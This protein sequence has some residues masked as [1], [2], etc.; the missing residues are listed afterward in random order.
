MATNTKQ[1]KRLLPRPAKGKTL[2][3]AMAITNKKYA[4]TLAKLAK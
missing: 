3:E 1:K 2:Q 4:Q